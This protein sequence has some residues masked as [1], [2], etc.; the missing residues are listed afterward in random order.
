HVSVPREQRE[1][2][3]RHTADTE[4]ADS[5]GKMK[6]TVVERTSTVTH[7]ELA[8]CQE[9]VVPSASVAKILVGTGGEAIIRMTRSATSNISKA[10]NMPVRLSLQV[11][12][13]K[14]TRRQK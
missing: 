3:Y 5:D 8:V 13:E 2:T 11:V 9:I 7:T 10:L 14:D 1:Y 12:V 4:G 6:R